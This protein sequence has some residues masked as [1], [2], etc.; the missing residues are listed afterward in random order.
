MVLGSLILITSPGGDQ[1]VL[2]CLSSDPYPYQPYLIEVQ[3]VIPLDGKV[4]ALS[5][6][7]SNTPF[8]CQSLKQIP[9]DEDPPLV[10]RQHMEPPKKFVLLTAQVHIVRYF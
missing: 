5:E 2:W 8:L 4:W 1:D 10:V 3:T 9:A 7:K 6:V